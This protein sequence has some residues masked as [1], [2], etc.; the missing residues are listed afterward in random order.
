MTEAVQQFA[1]AL[2]RI[3]KVDLDH[4]W[5]WLTAGWRDLQRAYRVSLPYGLLYAAVGAVLTAAIWIYGLF[6]L[7]LPLMAGF[8]LLGPILA[9]GLYQVSRQLAQGQA[10]GLAES[11]RAWTVN[12]TQIALM[13]L[14]LMLFLLAWVRLAT[15]LFALFFSTAVPPPDA[16]AVLNMLVRPGSIPFL[17]VGTAIGAV[18]AAVV[19][20]ISVISIPLLLDR[21]IDVIAAII[22]SVETVKRNVWTMALW[23]WLIALFIGVGLATMY[24]ALIVTLPLIGHASWHAYR[25]LIAWEGDPDL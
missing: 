15:L 14:A 1:A 10:V 23:A 5:M 13:G 21:E 16:V 24:V 8:M 20:A 25:D 3:R 19:F 22:T 9:V 17:V 6:H 4:P 2:P 7:V 11:L 12:P 18:L